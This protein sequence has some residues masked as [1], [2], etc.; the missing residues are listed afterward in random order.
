MFEK[1]CSAVEPGL[2]HFIKCKIKTTIVKHT[3]DMLEIKLVLR[4]DLKNNFNYENLKHL[5]LSDIVKM[6]M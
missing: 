5:N 1:F 6:K 2:K 4:S 3:K